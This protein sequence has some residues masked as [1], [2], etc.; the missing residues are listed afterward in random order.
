[1]NV[2]L[3]RVDL[4][5]ALDMIK[6]N[7]RF[8]IWDLKIN[9]QV[10]EEEIGHSYSDLLKWIVKKYGE[11]NERVNTA[12]WIDHTPSNIEYV[13]FLLELFLKQK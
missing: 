10:T 11:H 1:M 13:F 9:D 5:H 2:D 6:K 3:H 12:L 4:L 8:K 7:W